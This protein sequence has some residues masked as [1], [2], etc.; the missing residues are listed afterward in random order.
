MGAP[1]LHQTH[2]YEEL[3]AAGM[4]KYGHLKFASRYLHNFIRPDEHIMGVVYGR[5]EGGEA[6][7]V[8]TDL[9]IIFLDKKPLFA[10]T[11][12]LSYDAVSGVK[13]SAAGLFA[14]ITLHTRVGDYQLRY[15]NKTAA[16]NFVRYIE[17]R[18]LEQANGNRVAPELAPPVRLEAAAETF[19]QSHDTAVLSTVD[20]TGNVAGA[21]VYYT[22]GPENTLYILTRSGTTKARNILAHQQV[23]LTVFEEDTARTMQISGIVEIETNEPIKDE[24]FDRLTKHRSYWYHDA[25]PPVMQLV[26]GVFVV[27][28]IHF[29]SAIYHAYQHAKEDGRT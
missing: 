27:L 18:R 24:V 22:V 10:S 14:S 3:T 23:A 26:E 21:V 8:A 12:E 7:L 1:D 16:T 4:T 11:D 15:V 9:R 13:Y 5:Y 29:I 19:L 25:P 6:L 17:R 28:R 20:R 2:V